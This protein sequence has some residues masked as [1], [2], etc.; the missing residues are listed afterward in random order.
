[1]NEAAVFAA[2]LL[3]PTHLIRSIVS[4]SFLTLSL[5]D[6]LSRDFQTSA[7]C[8]TFRTVS[9][10]DDPSAVAGIRDGEVKW[11]VANVRTEFTDQDRHRLPSVLAE[12]ACSRPVVHCPHR[13]S[14]VQPDRGES[15][16][17]SRTGHSSKWATQ[18]LTLGRPGFYA[19]S[20][21]VR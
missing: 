10:S 15:H 5:I 8:T 11:L 16:S 1:M 13:G 14:W 19:V 4:G 18:W 7:I 2:S 20:D 9:V 21:K 17:G 6:E 3:L 12:R